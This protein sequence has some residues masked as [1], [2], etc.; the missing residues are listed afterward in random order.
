MTQENLDLLIGVIEEMIAAVPQIVIVLTTVVY[1][2][3]AIKSKV[4]SFPLQ[5]EETKK[6]LNTSFDDNKKQMNTTLSETQSKLLKSVDESNKRMEENVEQK[7][8]DM[9]GELLGY[10][11]ELKSNSDQTNILIRQSKM[12]MDVIANLV[13]QDQNQVKDEL[14]KNVVVKTMLSKK[15]LEQYP[16]LLVKELPILENAMK[17]VLTLIGQEKFEALLE[18]VGYGEGNK[19]V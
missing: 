11:E 18:K 4:N 10:K 2:L 15:E 7:L 13:S 8:L 14:A 19:K 3:N 16:Q 9:K 17:E 12:F 5:M 6:T 1:S